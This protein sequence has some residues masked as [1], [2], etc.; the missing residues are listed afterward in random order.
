MNKSLFLSLIISACA[1]AHEYPASQAKEVTYKVT[2]YREDSYDQQ[3]W[4]RIVSTASNAIKRSDQDERAT[5]EIAKALAE[6]IHEVHQC[7][8]D[9]AAGIHGSMSIEI[10]Q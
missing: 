7:Q 5:G 8:R 6:S 1:Q 9:G 2:L 3:S 10:G 4:D